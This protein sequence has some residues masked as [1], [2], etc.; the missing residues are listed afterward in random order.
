MAA[1]LA[2]ILMLGFI[3]LLMCE[4]YRLKKSILMTELSNK[5]DEL[6]KKEDELKK[7]DEEIKKLREDLH[8]AL[9][10]RS[11]VEDHIPH[12]ATDEGMSIRQKSQNGEIMVQFKVDDPSQGVNRIANVLQAVVPLIKD[13]DHSDIATIQT[14]YTFLYTIFTKV[15]NSRSFQWKTKECLLS[16]LEQVQKLQSELHTCYKRSTSY[17]ASDSGAT[18][19]LA[20]PQQESMTQDISQ[21]ENGTTSGGRTVQYDCAVPL[22]TIHSSPAEV[23]ESEQQKLNQLVEFG[24]EVQ[25]ILEELCKKVSTNGDIKI[26]E[27][28]SHGALESFL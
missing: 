23:G 21:E 17:P 5:K 27:K 8:A 14:I 11:I 19:P 20:Q 1:L 9:T 28:P 26:E 25:N 16:I 15:C 7:K 10:G 2:I 3:L 22:Q 24:G 6:S 13:W 18:V 12:E 4:R